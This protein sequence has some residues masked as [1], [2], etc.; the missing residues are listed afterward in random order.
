MSSVMWHETNNKCNQFIRLEWIVIQWKTLK[1]LYVKM[2][3]TN[4]C[5]RWPP[6]SRPKAAGIG[7]SPPH[8]PIPHRT[9]RICLLR[10]DLANITQG[11]FSANQRLFKTSAPARQPLPSAPAHNLPATHFRWFILDKRQLLPHITQTI[12]GSTDCHPDTLSRSVS[13]VVHFL[14]VRENRRNSSERRFWKSLTDF[15]LCLCPLWR[16]KLVFFGIPSLLL[17]WLS[18]AIVAPNNF[19]LVW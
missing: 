16:L 11:S 8:P 1:W 19:I 17:P 2:Q 13:L 10:V 14:S 5:S 6:A 3:S 18:H 4:G 15:S 12:S 9:G 7:P